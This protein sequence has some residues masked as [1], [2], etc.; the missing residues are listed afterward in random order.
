MFAF[1]CWFVGRISIILALPLEVGTRVHAHSRNS[2]DI[3]HHI[4][5]AGLCAPWEHAL[6]AMRSAF[7]KV[8]TFP[9]LRIKAGTVAAVVTLSCMFYLKCIRY[10]MIPH[11]LT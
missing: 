3:S 7:I 5:L 4:P 10:T 11:Q 9:Q 1:V 8:S 2:S 6:I